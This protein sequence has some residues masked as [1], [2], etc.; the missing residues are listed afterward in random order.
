VL[1]PQIEYSACTLNLAATGD[2]FTCGGSQMADPTAFYILNP[3]GR[4]PSAAWG[5][6]VRSE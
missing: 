5:Q 1:Q 3:Q 4:R 6:W 2:D